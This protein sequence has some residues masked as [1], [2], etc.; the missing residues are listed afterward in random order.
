MQARAERLARVLANGPTGAENCE[1]YRTRGGVALECD[2]PGPRVNQAQ[3]AAAGLGFML[4]GK[5]ADGRYRFEAY[6]GPGERRDEGGFT[7]PGGVR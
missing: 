5:V 1:V 2:I 7:L 6:A 3:S 4:H